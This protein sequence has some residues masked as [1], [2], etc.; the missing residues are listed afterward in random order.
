MN[1]TSFFYWL[2][3]AFTALFKVIPFVGIGVDY[4]FMAVIA[5][6][7]A[8]WLLVLSKD[9]AGKSSKKLYPYVDSKESEKKQ[10]EISSTNFTVK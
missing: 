9:E 2:G 5:I 10:S 1:L 6:L 7:L 8:Y 3:D 4:V